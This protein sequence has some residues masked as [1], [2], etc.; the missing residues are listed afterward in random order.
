MSV[1]QNYTIL[2]SNEARITAVATLMTAM[3]ED[4]RD[5]FQF[6]L[7]PGWGDFV[8]QELAYRDEALKALNSATVMT[9]EDT[10]GALDGALLAT[11][12]RELHTMRRL[13]VDG[14]FG[15]I[16][17]LGR[18]DSLEAALLFLENPK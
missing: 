2:M 18:L 7:M 6:G 8:G 11:V 16:K 3:R 13:I 5:L 4:R 12:L 14:A 9:R 17:G 1:T 15:D 10:H